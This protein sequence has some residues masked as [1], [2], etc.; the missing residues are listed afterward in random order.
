MDAEP[1][2]NEQESPSPQPNIGPLSD[3]FE[4]VSL[5]DGTAQAGG[6]KAGS[7]AEPAGGIAQPPKAARRILLFSGTRQWIEALSLHRL[8]VSGGTPELLRPAHTSTTCSTV[9]QTQGSSFCGLL[10]AWIIRDWINC[11]L[12][13]PPAAAGRD[14]AA[15]VIARGQFPGRHRCAAPASRHDEGTRHIRR[16]PHLNKLHALRP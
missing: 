10:C 5:D 9:S 7:K 8:Y 1:A 6:G 4:D 12:R 3:G 15:T 13:E 14:G 11:R 16:P 2:H